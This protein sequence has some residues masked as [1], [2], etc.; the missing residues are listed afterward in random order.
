[1]KNTW[2][3]QIE[4]WNE[5]IRQGQGQQVARELRHIPREEIPLEQLAKIANLTS[6]I[7]QPSIGLRLLYPRLRAESNLKVGMALDAF[8]EY[9]GCLIEVGA[10]SEARQVLRDLRGRTPRSKFYSALL[11]FK[12][13]N[14]EA[15]IPLLEEY[16]QHLQQVTPGDY[17]Q[18]V[19]RVNLASS[20]V[21]TQ[22]WEKGL[23][24]LAELKT[25]LKTKGHWLLLGNCYEIE[26]QIYYAQKDHAQALL[27]L[28]ESERHLGQSK[29][30]GWVYCKK[31]Q[32]LNR[33][34]Q[35]KR[36]GQ[37]DARKLVDE[38]ESVKAL[39]YGMGSWESLRELDLHWALLTGHSQLLNHVYFGSPSPQ[40]REKIHRLIRDEARELEVAGGYDW[41]PLQEP[42]ETPQLIDFKGLIGEFNEKGRS[43]LLKKLLLILFS[44]FYA[45]FRIG[46]LFSTLFEGEFYDLETSPDRVFQLI[47]RLRGWLEEKDAGC[48]IHSGSRGYTVRFTKNRGV[49]LERSLVEQG[50]QTKAKLHYLHL[51]ERFGQNAFTSND[52]GQSLGCSARTANRVLKELKAEG[53]VESTG[54][55][56]FTKFRLVS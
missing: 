33:I 25:E 14:Y 26:S 54:K 36:G 8:T 2:L 55:G 56:R 45:P 6:R 13:W 30:M 32:F 31:W 16:L 24:F 48:A 50:L 10:L 37:F 5:R 29:N 49:S 47:R 4:T 12:E 20:Y 9:A 23:A 46:Q 22:Q 41:V 39:A 15:A 35:D 34:Y 42:G 51:H 19:V 1:M 53:K 3:S 21:N 40:Y 43:F 17:H 28:T 18:L 38:Y 11:L 7:N 44:D 27:A 52:V